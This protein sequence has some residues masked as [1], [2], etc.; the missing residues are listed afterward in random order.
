M[1][2]FFSICNSTLSSNLT[3]PRFKNN[4]ITFNQYKLFSANINNNLWSIK[5]VDCNTNDDFYFLNINKSNNEQIFFLA[6]KQEV[7]VENNLENELKSVNDFTDTMPDFRANLEISNN[8]G[9][10]SSYQSEYPLSMIQKKGSILS[11]L[12][13]LLNKTADKNYLFFKNIYK[14]PIKENFKIYFV[15]INLKEVVD[16]KNAYTNQTNV[17]EIELKYIN[18]NIFIYS[19]NFLGIPIFVSIKDYHISMEH[20]HPPHLYIWG[21]DKFKRISILKNKVY[22]IIQKNI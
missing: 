8:K 12:N 2:Y 17:Y 10:F 15:D 4:G 16:I 21:D 14:K 9:G 20:T 5:E 13:T 11:P 22:E 19:D 3:I 18:S 6:T 1:N 7:E